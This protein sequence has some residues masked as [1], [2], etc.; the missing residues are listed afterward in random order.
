MKAELDTDEARAKRQ[1]K[2]AFRQKQ[3]YAQVKD[4]VQDLA[5]FTDRHAQMW[6]L[7]REEG[8]SRKV[9]G[10]AGAAATSYVSETLGDFNIPGTLRTRF[11]GMERESGKGGHGITNGTLLVDVEITPIKGMSQVVEVPVQVKN[12]YM[13]QPAVMIHQGCPMV[14]AQ[15]AIDDLI[16]SGTFDDKIKP[17]RK[18]MFSS[19]K[20]AEFSKSAGECIMCGEGTDEEGNCSNCAS[21]PGRGHSDASP[22]EQEEAR[23]WLILNDPEGAEFWASLPV[24]TDFVSEKAQNIR[25]FGPENDLEMEGAASRI[26]PQQVDP[27]REMDRAKQQE[28]D[29]Q[30]AKRRRLERNL[31]MKKLKEKRPMVAGAIA[32]L[33]CRIGYEGKLLN[34]GSPVFI[35]AEENGGFRV[36]EPSGEQLLV[37]PEHLI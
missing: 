33:A 12:G 16:A 30:I 6:N 18:H 27:R 2:R 32:R 31:D 7:G 25:D 26:P 20:T 1:A 11:A 37:M 4:A 15:S 3:L 29:E 24:G 19:P 22:E 9:N 34:E 17:D 21:A 36:K 13:L 8:S 35:V 14:I 10:H 5:T 28:T 23:R